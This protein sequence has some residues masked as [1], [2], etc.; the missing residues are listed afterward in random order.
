MITSVRPLLIGVI[1]TRPAAPLACWRSAR[2][3][4]AARASREGYGLLET[5]EVCSRQ[6]VDA[7]TYEAVEALAERTG[8]RAIMTLGPVDREA[9]QRITELYGVVVID[10]SIGTTDATCPPGCRAYPCRNRQEDSAY[11]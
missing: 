4:V 1:Y 2:A 8:A 6:E 10:A 5:F 7:A 11:A 9:V 3:L